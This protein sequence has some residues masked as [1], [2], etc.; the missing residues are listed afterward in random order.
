M[1]LRIAAKNLWRNKRRT[2]IALAAIVIGSFMVVMLNGFANGVQGVM[3]EG[4]VKA[5]VG[6]IQVH[7]RGFVDAIEGAPLKLNLKDTPAL[8]KTI[9]AVPGV[10]A[11]SGRITFVGLG[12]TG[13]KSSMVFVQAMDPK[14][15]RAV[16]PLATRFIQ[17]TSLFDS[18]LANAAIVGGQLGRNLKVS[19]GDSFTLTAQGPAGQT[20]AL[21][22]VVEG[23]IPQT[24]PFS[25]KRLMAVPLDFAQGLL[26]MEGLITEYAVAV[27]DVREIDAVAERLRGAVGPDLEVHTWLQIMPFFKDMLRRIRYV[28][29]IAG[30]VLF[31]IVMIG[32]VNVMVMSVYERVREIGTMMALGV[33][34][35]LVLRLFLAEGLFLGLIGG[36]VGCSVGLAIV[37][38]A[39][40][41]GVPFKA[42]GS[43]GTIP[44]HPFATPTLILV[45]VA[46]A[47]LGSV[48]A[49][50]YP[51]LKASRLRPVDALRAL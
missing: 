29:G 6:A 49:S 41:R 46:A 14:G 39:G 45:V 48:L 21:D 22:V 43:S 25:G 8:R 44:M 4:M 28:L 51:A 47:S 15:E 7:R 31:V 12:S 11:V 42:P 18:R 50:L 27:D 17:G 3:I 30:S 2:L 20:N 19:P 35:R 9:L 32:I 38:I 5:Q 23:T 16:V 13:A 33:R 36:G 34:R 26:R 24:D 37:S 40:A 10:T 1:I